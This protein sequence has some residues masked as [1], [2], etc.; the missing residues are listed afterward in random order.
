MKG[1]H[2]AAAVAGAGVLGVGGFLL[3][4]RKKK[5][6]SKGKNPKANHL[7]NPAQVD[8]SN[9][10]HNGGGVLGEAMN[11]TKTVSGTAESVMGLIGKF[12]SSGSSGA[13]GSQD[14]AGS[15][16]GDTSSDDDSGD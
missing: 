7:Q 8:G 3:L 2:I 5:A 11:V 10:V 13:S 4:K 14:Q 15:D 9:A 6:G 1:W 12:T 16:A